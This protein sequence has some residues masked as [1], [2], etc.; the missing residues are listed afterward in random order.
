[1]RQ[2][3]KQICKEPKRNISLPGIQ[4][5]EMGK[6]L[7]SCLG[8]GSFKFFF[9]TGQIM[10]G[11]GIRTHDI[12]IIFIFPKSEHKEVPDNISKQSIV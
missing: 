8:F 3:G 4:L 5:K 1:M 6:G 7:V 9:L 12:N 10:L 2:F 11:K